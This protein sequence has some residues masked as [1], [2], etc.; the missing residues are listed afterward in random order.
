MRR[1]ITALAVLL[2]STAV[3][4]AGEPATEKELV[5]EEVA[6]ANAWDAPQFVRAN[7]AGNVF[8]LRADTLE[9]FPLTE[10][11]ELGEPSKLEALGQLPSKVDAAALS[12]DGDVWMLSTD[13]GIRRFVDG[14]EKAVPA[15]E[16]AH[17]GIGFWQGVPVVNIVPIPILW[18]YLDHGRKGQIPRLVALDGD[19]WNVLL[20]YP[21][22]PAAGFFQRKAPNFA[23]YE[24]FLASDS[25]GRLWAARALEYDI[26]QLTP[27]GKPRAHLSIEG[28]FL[29]DESDEEKQCRIAGLR[30]FHDNPKVLGL[31]EGRDRRMYF[32]TRGADWLDG[33]VL[34]RYNPVT[35]ELTRLS[36]ER[37]N[38]INPYIPMNLAA[39]KKGLYFAAEKLRKGRWMLSWETLE[40]ADWKP[41]PESEFL[42]SP[43]AELPAMKPAR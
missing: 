30:R 1:F 39:G 32:L 15:L 41:V 27:S 17:S 25:E 26:E 38:S 29:T 4:V 22:L 16:W 18:D 34:D 10:G 7:R 2:S 23:Q 3:A 6:T 12:P 14:K 33:L 42:H 19:R 5:P 36:V 13:S 35:S 43:A 37:P 9:I 20:E 8:V 11:G 21:D 24:R 31:T 40:S 28:Y